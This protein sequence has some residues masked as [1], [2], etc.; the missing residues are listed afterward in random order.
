VRRERLLIKFSQENIY[1]SNIYAVYELGGG[2]SPKLNLASRTW[3]ESFGNLLHGLLSPTV[4]PTVK[5]ILLEVYRLLP[6]CVGDRL[7]R[8]GTFEDYSQLNDG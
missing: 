6:S 1:S 7:G 3:L 5:A 4:L 8:D 2:E